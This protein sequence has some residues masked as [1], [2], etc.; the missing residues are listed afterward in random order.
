[1]LQSWRTQLGVGSN[2][3]RPYGLHHSN[4][5]DA[6]TSC[7]TQT[8][9]M[10]LRVAPLRPPLLVFR[11]D[12]ADSRVVVPSTDG[13]PPS[14]ALRK[15][16]KFW[17]LLLRGAIVPSI[18]SSDG[19]RTMY[20]CAD[21]RLLRCLLWYSNASIDFSDPVDSSSPCDI[22][23]HHIVIARVSIKVGVRFAYR[24]PREEMALLLAQSRGTPLSGL[25]ERSKLL[26]VGSCF[27]YLHCRST[28]TT[29]SQ[30]EC[31]VQSQSSLAKS[32]RQ[33]PS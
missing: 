33:I 11:T 28:R 24:R 13:R 15:V 31:S 19:P 9:E 22:T 18:R 32:F 2:S 26:P 8:A 10:L 1:M 3:R 30:K 5:R 21:M 27:A 16:E 12:A 6:L 23:L 25:L 17:T 4:S 20:G 14:D 29:P 7:T